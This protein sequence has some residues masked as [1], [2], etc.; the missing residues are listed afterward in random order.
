M[1]E[2]LFGNTNEDTTQKEEK[3]GQH[4]KKEGNMFENLFENT[5]EDTTQKKEG[6]HEKKEGNMFENL[7]GNT[8]EDTSQKKE[9]QH[10]TEEGQHETEERQDEKEETEKGEEKKGIFNFS[11]NFIRNSLIFLNLGFLLDQLLIFAPLLGGSNKEVIHPYESIYNDR[12]LLLKNNIKW[13]KISNGGTK[14]KYTK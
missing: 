9:G 12:M 3:E 4:E 5:N 10:E 13:K 8:N 1:F 2:N 14:K 11:T 7:F 6:Q